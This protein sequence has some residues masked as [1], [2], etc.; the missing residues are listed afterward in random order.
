MQTVCNR[1]QLISKPTTLKRHLSNLSIS[2][3]T[4]STM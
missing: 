4:I 3:S 2:L 1:S